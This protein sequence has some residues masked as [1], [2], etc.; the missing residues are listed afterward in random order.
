MNS[1]AIDISN[2]FIEKGVSHLKLH[3]LLY[4]TQLWY[5]VKNKKLLFN[6]SIKA[7]LYG[8]VVETVWQ[9]FRY[10]KKNDLIPKSKIIETDFTN[11]KQHLNEVW[12]AYGHLSGADLIELSHT[13]KPWKDARIGVLN[14]EPSNTILEINITTTQN[15]T[16]SSG[17]IP[18]QTDINAMGK[19]ESIVVVE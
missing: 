14:S 16:L 19:F 18:Y 4:Y 8:P 1:K 9:K 2:F 6:D 13:E 17:K 5:F 3:K 11:L 15:F 12:N 7:W 10:T